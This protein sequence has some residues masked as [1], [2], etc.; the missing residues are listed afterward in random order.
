MS[1]PDETDEGLRRIGRL[2]RDRDVEG[3]ALEIS[4]SRPLL[5]RY[6]AAR[7]LGKLGDPRALEA[8]ALAVRDEHKDVRIAAIRSLAAI[9]DPAAIEVLLEAR[10]D[11]HPI[12]R[13]WALG[14]LAQHRVREAVPDLE[15]YLE[16]P[17]WY[18]RRWAARL[19][20]LIGDARAL[21]ALERARRA[22]RIP[23][24]WVLGRSIRALRRASSL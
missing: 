24:R 22:E 11:P 7:A 15:M 16:N 4:K 2:R 13:E 18:R 19:L 17:S 5:V 9:D 1:A 14:G 8:L 20:A 12:A 23:R 3:L 21:E 10:Q 6:A